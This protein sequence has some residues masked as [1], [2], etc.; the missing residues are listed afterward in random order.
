MRLYVTWIC[1]SWFK[2]SKKKSSP[3]WWFSDE[4]HGTIRNPSKNLQK[5]TN[6][7]LEECEMFKSLSPEGF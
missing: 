4:S 1:L 7:R 6:P 5:Q 3:K 2:S